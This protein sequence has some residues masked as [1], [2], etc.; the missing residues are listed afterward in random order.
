MRKTNKDLLY[1]RENSTQYSVMT[2]ENGIQKT[3]HIRITDS[4]CCIVEMNNIVLIMY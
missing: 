3:V 4:P 2:Y 1:S